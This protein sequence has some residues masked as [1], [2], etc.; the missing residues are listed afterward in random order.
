MGVTRSFQAGQRMLHS[1]ALQQV[2]LLGE[3]RDECF[4]SGAR[5]ACDPSRRPNTVAPAYSNAVVSVSEP[6]TISTTESPGWTRR[7]DGFANVL[8]ST[9]K[10][11]PKKTFV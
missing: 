9:R 1:I 7:A 11:C 3:A 8:P 4:P 2:K 5:A 6:G 10:F